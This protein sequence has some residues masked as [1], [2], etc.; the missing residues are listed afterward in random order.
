MGYRKLSARPRHHAQADGAIEDFKKTYGPP[1][2]QAI[3]A[4]RSEQSA[5][6]YPASVGI[7]PGQ[8]GDPRVLVLISFT[9]LERHFLNQVC[10]TPVRLSGHLASTTSRH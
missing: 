4:I 3:S 10:R 2:P 7:A 5:S 8:D 9:A 1:R 6:T